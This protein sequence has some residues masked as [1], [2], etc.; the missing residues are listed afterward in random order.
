MVTR[1]ITFADR[2]LSGRIEEWLASR[3][4]IA[5]VADGHVSRFRPVS[6]LAAIHES[7]WLPR[8]PLKEWFLPQTE[9]LYACRHGAEGC[10]EVTSGN[11]SARPRVIFGVRPCE[12]RALTLLDRVFLGGAVVDPYYRAR[13]ERTTLVGIACAAPRTV[14]FCTSVGGSPYG[15]EGLDVL[16]VPDGAGFIAEI[17]TEKGLALFPGLTS[18]VPDATGLGERVAAGRAAAE[19][20]M[21]DRFPLEGL[22]EKVEAGFADPAWDR[23]HEACI[24]CGTCAFL[25]PT[26]HCFDLVQEIAGGGAGLGNGTSRCLRDWD[27]CMF[28]LFTREASGANPRPTGKERMRQRFSHKFA[29]F[30]ATHGAAACVGCGRC[31]TFCPTATDIREVA[32]RLQ[33]TLGRSAPAGKE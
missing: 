11:A 20:G 22:R 32:G 5:P 3:E 16:L 31:I 30:P 26:C 21:R 18:A 12:A 14:C 23:I 19:A 2:L 24:G 29:W 9:C 13:R 25:C 28:P 4:V 7:D 6:D 33:E 8:L 10:L 17:L 1:R 27:A 15:T